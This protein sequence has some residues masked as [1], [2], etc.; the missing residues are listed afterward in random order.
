MNVSTMTFFFS[1]KE[2]RTKLDRYN[3]ITA[4]ADKFFDFSVAKKIPFNWKV[5]CVKS[6]QKVLAEWLRQDPRFGGVGDC[7]DNTYSMYDTDR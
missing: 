6:S 7:W 4:L 3:E 5:F 2:T 1:K